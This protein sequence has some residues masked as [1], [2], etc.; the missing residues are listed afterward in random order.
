[1]EKLQTT[2]PAVPVAAEELEKNRGFSESGFS[3]SRNGVLIFQSAADSASRLIWYDSAGKELGQIPEA[4]YED[5]DFSPDGH[6]LAV[7]SD[8]DHDGKYFIRIYDLKRGLSTRLT[9]GGKDEVPTWS[10]DGKQITFGAQG[11]LDIPISQ[12]PADGSGSPQVLLKGDRLVPCDWSADGHLIF[13]DF[14]NGLPTLKIYNHKDQKITTFALQGAEAQF[15]PDGRW[16]AYSGIFVQPF[17]G[18][19]A[20][21]QISNTV[22]AQPRWSHDG[23]EIFYLQPDR[24]LMAAKFDS[25]TGMAGPPHV[26]FQTRVVAPDYD[27]FQYDVAPDGRFLINSLPTDHSSP[28]TLV[29]DW[30][31][32]LKK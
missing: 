15:S 13:M 8:D 10:P 7:S 11:G 31:A 3:V 16:I 4:G 30:P 24:K 27:M 32:L 18:P 5:P 6:L 23:R 17:P 9:N 28:L 22:S 26:L 19:G 14:A 1:V 25:R 29:V 20:R 21:I 2:G 12:V